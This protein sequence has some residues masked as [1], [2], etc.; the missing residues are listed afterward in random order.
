MKDDKKSTLKDFL[1]LLNLDGRKCYLIYGNEEPEKQLIRAS[2]NFG[3]KLPSEE[4]PNGERP[5]L[6]SSARNV[7]VGP[8]M[9]FEM[10]ILDKAAVEVLEEKYKLD[11]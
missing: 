9:E 6:V 5:I 3:I 10:V 2:N 1:A 8:L 7:I 4:F 11:L